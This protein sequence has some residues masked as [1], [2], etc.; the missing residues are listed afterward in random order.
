MLADDW[1]VATDDGSRAAHW[2]HSVAVTEAGLTVLTAVDGGAARLGEAYVP[3]D[4]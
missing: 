1:T 2:E 4:V 3:I